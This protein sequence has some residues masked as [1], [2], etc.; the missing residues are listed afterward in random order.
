MDS[1]VTD[2]VFVE[3]LVE[4]SIIVTY[5][6]KIF[7][8]YS[9]DFYQMAENTQLGAYSDLISKIEIPS[10]SSVNSVT[11]MLQMTRAM[12]EAPFYPHESWLSLHSIALQG[13][14]L[15]LRLVEPYM[16]K[17]SS[18]VVPLWRKYI[19]LLCKTANA[20]PVSIEHLESTPRK[21]CYGLTTDFRTKI[22]GIVNN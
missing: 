7:E 17:P 4:F 12:I 8:V 19:T 9:T 2:V 1:I 21:G 6:S 22:S 11:S 16:P 5:T 10:L 13:S 15:L 3:V 18:N 20:K 14:F